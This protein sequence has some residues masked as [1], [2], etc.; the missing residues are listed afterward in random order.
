M[1]SR[2]RCHILMSISDLRMSIHPTALISSEAHL[3]PGVSV[4]PYA[5]IE[6]FTQIGEGCEIRAH[7][8]I[9]RFTSLE[10]GNIVHEGAVIGGEPQDTSFTECKSYL[11]IGARNQIRECVTI[12][13][14]S[15]PNSATE[16]GSD[17]F[18]MAH[19]HVAHDCRVGN[20]VVIAN[21]VALA[22]HVEIEDQ[23]FLSGGACVHQ[24]C[25]VGRL[26][27]IGGNA[28]I[29]QDCLPFV[30]TDGVPGR[31]R[32]L[33]IVGL[34]RSGFKSSE[35][36]RLKQAY[37]ILLRSGLA[38]EAALECL[39]RMEDPLV[40][41]MVRFIGRSERGFCHE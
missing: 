22:G 35:L 3:G 25:R 9:K 27:M 12:H 41:H 1:I 33:N 31:A 30:I 11:S 18:I 23:A 38:L 40:D 24:F 14:G 32:G 16:I 37:R 36:Q 2:A 13:R 17:C 7:A 21:N 15:T 26:A 10:P 29:V 19:A 4:G 8:I 20:R 5:I 34:R 6:P 39:R 28:K